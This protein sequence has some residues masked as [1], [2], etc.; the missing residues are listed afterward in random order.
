MPERAFLMQS[1]KI[2]LISIKKR[3]F[4]FIIIFK[5]VE[6]WCKNK[7]TEKSQTNG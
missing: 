6:C 5:L 4:Y 7:V 1:T 2:Q 3:I